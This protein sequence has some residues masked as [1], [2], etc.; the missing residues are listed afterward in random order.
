MPHRHTIKKCHT[1]ISY[2]NG[3]KIKNILY[4]NFNDLNKEELEFYE[5]NQEKFEL[6][7]CDRTN[8][9]YYSDDL[10]W[11]VEHLGYTAVCEEVYDMLTGLEDPTS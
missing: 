11:N 6:N 7:T 8:V 1:G 2:F 5:E 4:R 9:I 3:M 10:V